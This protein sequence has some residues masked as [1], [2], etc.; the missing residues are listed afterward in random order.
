MTN[1][2]T[3]TKSLVSGIAF[4]DTREINPNIIDVANETGYDDLMQMAGRYKVSEQPNYHHYVNEDLQQVLV[5]DVAGVAG[6]GTPVLTVTVTTTNF[7]RRDGKY[8]FNNNKVGKISSAITTASGKDSFTITSVDGTN[9]TAVQGDKITSLGISTGEGSDAVDVLTYGQ[10]KYFNL[11]EHMKDKTQITDIQNVTKVVTGTGLYAYT[12]SIN[13]AQS[14]KETISATLVGGVKSINEFGTASPTLTDQFGNSMQT[15]GGI[16]Q[17]IGNYGI[18][19]AVATT[20]TFLFSDVD[21]LLDQMLAVKAPNDFLLLC[22]S[23]PKR[24]SDQLWKNLPSAN[25]M[26]SVKINF[27]GKEIDFTV[28]KVSY[29]GRQLEF[30][31]LALLDHPQLFGSNNPVGKTIYG[32]P[33]DKVKVQVGPGGKGG[34]ETRIGVRYL[35]NPGFAKNH[36]TEMVHEWYTDALASSPTSGKEVLTCHISTTQGNE[37]LGTRQ[38]FKMRVAI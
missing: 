16:D 29:G 21:I 25:V 14:F 15:T 24:L 37:C 34:V 7:A 30:S 23:K 26:N 4:M 17:E 1:R 2:S 27:D 36:G 19:A 8:K 28:D 32:I 18:N 13:Q 9:L 33:K 38:M 31:S 22:P 6:T 11:V 3:T 35:P 12:Q 10:T 20:G 5:F